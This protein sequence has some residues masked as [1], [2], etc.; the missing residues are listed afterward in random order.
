MRKIIFDLDLTLIDTTCLEEY[1][2][3][4][5]WQQA[6]NMIPQTSMYLGIQ[7]VFEI[8]KK[9]NI[10]T[11]IVTTTPRP[12]AEKLIDYYKIPAQYIVSF[13]DAKPVKPHPAQM[14]KALELMNT[15]P[16][17]TIS[18]GD[19][20]IDIQASNAAGIES[21]ACFWGTKEKMLLLNSGYTHAIISP[22]EILTLIR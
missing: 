12:Y 17:E 5:N 9:H 8:I 20:A 15:T 13:H 7:E 1:R 22:R 2:N 10:I 4:K 6:Y 16:K 19:R 14:L 3:T 11:A 21:V 18:F